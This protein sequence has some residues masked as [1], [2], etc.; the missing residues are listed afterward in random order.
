MDTLVTET[1][2]VPWEVHHSF[3]IGPYKK[4]SVTTR[5]FNFD[6]IREVGR[7]ELLE[8][9]VKVFTHVYTVDF[10]VANSVPRL[11]EKHGFIFTCHGIYDKP[12]MRNTAPIHQNI[13]C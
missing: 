9:S 4:E 7:H 5:I 13:L 6:F 1:L 2:A 10:H 8:V 11:C 12:P 3:D